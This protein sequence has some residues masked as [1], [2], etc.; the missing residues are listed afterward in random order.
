MDQDC[1]LTGDARELVKQAP[2][3]DFVLWDPDY[4]VGVDFEG[5][6]GKMDRD[7]ALELVVEL[8]PDL[9]QRCRSKQAVVFWGGS[10]ERVA[11]FLS[12]PVETIWPVHYMGIWHK[13][14]GAPASGDG[15]SRSF[16]V[17]F[18]L[19]AGPKP[20]AEWRFFSDVLSEPRIIGSFKDALGHPSQK[21]VALLEKL[22]RFFTLPGQTV[23]DPTAGVCSTAAAAKRTGRHF[24]CFEINPTWAEIGRQRILRTPAPFPQMAGLEQM[25]IFG[26]EVE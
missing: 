14:N 21:P 23:L 12:S 10:V 1:I 18:W 16:E 7:E 26:G 9:L 17:W 4:G 2:K 6:R 3:V 24:I 8:L 11:A 25:G 22:L 19:K 20:R 13:P 5:G 15:I